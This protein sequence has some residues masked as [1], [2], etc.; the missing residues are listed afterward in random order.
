M[1]VWYPWKPYLSLYDVP[2]IIVSPTLC[3]SRVLAHMEICNMLAQTYLVMKNVGDMTYCLTY[4]QTNHVQLW[5][6]ESFYNVIHV[7][8]CIML[9]DELHFLVPFYLVWKSLIFNP[10][11][12]A[13]ILYNSSNSKQH[14]TSDTPIALWCWYMLML[15]ICA[16]L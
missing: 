3:S 12:F 8:I 5:I 13:Y 16:I 11:Y 9:V 10:F 6:R 1:L 14:A 7:C 15:T 4:G 2:S